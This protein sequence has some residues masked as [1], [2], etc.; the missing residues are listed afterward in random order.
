MFSL[1]YFTTGQKKNYGNEIPSCAFFVLVFCQTSITSV[2]GEA[3]KDT[4]VK[5]VLLISLD[6]Y[7]HCLLCLCR[8]DQ[9][10]HLLHFWLAQW[11]VDW[12]N[13]I[14]SHHDTHHRDSPLEGNFNWALFTC[15]CIDIFK[16]S[17]IMR[18]VHSVAS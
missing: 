12:V 4:L 10:W 5:M 9:Q 18:I 11:T 6:W 15:L 17:F 3:W 8:Y 13:H 2:T 7:C 16:Y 14:L 1:L